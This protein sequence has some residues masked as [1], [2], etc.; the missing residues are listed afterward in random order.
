MT[1]SRDLR[2]YNLPHFHLWRIYDLWG[3]KLGTRNIATDSA[4]KLPF[5]GESL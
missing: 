5:L 1:F 3:D 2:G 4:V